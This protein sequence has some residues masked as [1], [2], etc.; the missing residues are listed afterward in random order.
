MKTIIKFQSIVFLLLI[1]FS[2]K[3]E[4]ENRQVKL[5]S[6]EICN[7]KIDLLNIENKIIVPSSYLVITEKDI[8]ADF[9]VGEVET[10]II[11]KEVSLSETEYVP[12]KIAIV[13]AKLKKI[14]N[15]YILSVKKAKQFTVSCVT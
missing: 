9:N 14:V 4:R 2:C 7:V 12:L 5:E 1:L 13:D 11:G 10:R 8:K 3:N 15:N 6:L